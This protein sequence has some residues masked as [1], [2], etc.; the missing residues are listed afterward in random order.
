MTPSS[1]TSDLF[2]QALQYVSGEGSAAERDVFEQRL[3]VDPTAC[4]AVADAVQLVEALRLA[5]PRSSVSPTARRA[6]QPV[7]PQVEM[8]RSPRTPVAVLATAVAIVLIVGG[9][10]VR[11][12]QSPDHFAR[13]DHAS[14]PAGQSGT[15]LDVWTSLSEPESVRDDHAAEDSS[16]TAVPEVPDWMFEALV[17]A[18]SRPESKGLNDFLIDEESL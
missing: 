12:I 1:E 14:H 3:A 11:A 4:E 16:A 7:C 15:V 18:A 8:A 6:P 5:A 9:I 17:A 10:G 2:F 13:W